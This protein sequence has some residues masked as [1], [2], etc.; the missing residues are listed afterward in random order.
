M[1]DNTTGKDSRGH[2]FAMGNRAAV[3]NRGGGRP[4][5]PYRELLERY[6]AESL[7]LLWQVAHDA[8]HPWHD[9]HGFNAAR[10]LARICT[11]K[12]TAIEPSSETG[13]T[14][15]DIAQRMAERGRDL[16]PAA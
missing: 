10:E 13:P 3:G 11:P 4:R 14:F 1:N 16:G 6:S 7:D 12:L 2:R 8:S 5:A 9:L 15:A